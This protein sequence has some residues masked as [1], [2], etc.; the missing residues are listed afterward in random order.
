[1]KLYVALV[2]T[3]LVGCASCEKDDEEIAPFPGG[4]WSEVP[5]AFYSPNL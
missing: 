4:K 5:L 1:M 2:V 3:I